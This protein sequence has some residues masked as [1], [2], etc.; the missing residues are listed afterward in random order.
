MSC[1]YYKQLIIMYREISAM[2]IKNENR[3]DFCIPLNGYSL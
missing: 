3:N 2:R 1:L